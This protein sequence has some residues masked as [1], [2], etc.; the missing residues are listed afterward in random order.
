VPTINPYPL[1]Q[2]KNVVFWTCSFTNDTAVTHQNLNN[3]LSLSLL[4]IFGNV[5][6]CAITVTALIHCI[7][8][9]PSKTLLIPHFCKEFTVVSVFTHLPG[10]STHSESYENVGHSSCWS[11]IIIWRFHPLGHFS[12]VNV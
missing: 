4:L 1:I 3:S 9:V 12:H 5:A 11:Q 6:V 8:F 2:K 10:V 7:C